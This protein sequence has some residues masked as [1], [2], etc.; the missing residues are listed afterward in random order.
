MLGV[1]YSV[2]DYVLQKDLENTSRLLVDEA[3]DTLYASTSGETTNGRLRDALNIISENLPV[4]LRS[5]F[6]KTLASLAA[7]SHVARVT[8]VKSDLDGGSFFGLYTK[9]RGPITLRKGRG[10]STGE[11]I[12]TP[13][14]GSGRD[15][16]AS[17]WVAR[18]KE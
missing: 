15:C 1:C 18:T 5:T 14:G 17:T 12:N 8:K 4:A 3:G 9:T 13:L 6:A 2:T 10:F 16:I 11:D 7:S